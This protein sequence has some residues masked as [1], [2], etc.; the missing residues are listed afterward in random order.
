[1]KIKTGMIPCN[2]SFY[3]YIYISIL[4]EVIITKHLIEIWTLIFLLKL[5]GTWDKLM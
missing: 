2:Y 5:Y 1:M 3:L 4:N